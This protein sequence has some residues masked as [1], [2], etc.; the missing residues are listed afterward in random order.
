M[1]APISPLY[2][3]QPCLK[4]SFE[5]V[6][7]GDPSAIAWEIGCQHPNSTFDAYLSSRTPPFSMTRLYSSADREWVSRTS[8]A[9]RMQV[10]VPPGEWDLRLGGLL[11]TRVCEVAAATAFAPSYASLP[12]FYRSST[13]TQVPGARGR[14]WRGRAG[15]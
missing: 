13:Y 5:F 11:L 12:Q 9:M 2:I 3:F 4:P 1:N 7:R 8:V 6:R 15:V 10:K 14:A